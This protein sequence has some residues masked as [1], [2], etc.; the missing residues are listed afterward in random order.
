[1]D[2]TTRLANFCADL[3]LSEVPQDVVR[4]A[5]RCVL[6]FLGCVLGSLWMEDETQ[7][8][9]GY[10]RSLG[11]RE[12]A[13]VLALGLRTSCRS[14][15]LAHGA[16]AEML[17]FQDTYAPAAFHPG[18][19]VLPSALAMAE[20]GHRSGKDLLA[21]VVAGYEACLRIA[22]AGGQS[23]VDRGFMSTG[24][25]GA[26]GATVAAG[27]VLGLGRE[28]LANALGIAGYMLPFSA[29]ENFFS[30]GYSIRPLNAGQAARTGIEAAMLAAQ[31]YTASDRILEGSS[32]PEW[33]FC[34]MAGGQVDL[35]RITVG[36]GQTYRIMDVAFKAYPCCGL[37]QTAVEAALD[38]ARAHQLEAGQVESI[39]VRTFASSVSRVGGNYPTPHC[40]FVTCQF[41][42]PYLIAAAI[43]YRQ[44]TLQQ[45]TPQAIHDPE[46]LEL[47]G[48]V[49][50]V[51]DPD[52]T[53][54][55][56]SDARPSIVE[57][58]LRNGRRHTARVDFRTGD[59]ARPM[60]DAQLLAKFDGL[61]SQALSGEAIERCK[62]IV[63]GLEK[64]GDMAELVRTCRTS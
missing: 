46:V 9:A 40:S 41:S 60:S 1:M 13:A 43:K 11:D 32:K 54:L 44:L 18:S 25:V 49:K 48:R 50:T 53:K 37:P 62:E 42:M 14:A 30:G 7:R 15:A 63:L 4:M 51:E 6:D 17:E 21:A 38:L 35:N 23:Y 27:K 20:A 19:S 29:A 24:T 47:S 28:A 55:A 2:Y 64:L 45:F 58:A 5:K 57:V 10:V 59:P 61:A 33:G 31:G 22:A 34:S 36:L 52:L 8:L 16:M 26:F 56:T 12:E 3:T 39:L